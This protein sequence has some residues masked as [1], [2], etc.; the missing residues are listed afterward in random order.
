VKILFIGVNWITK[1]IITEMLFEDSDEELELRVIGQDTAEWFWTEVPRLK[2]YMGDERV[3]YYPNNVLHASHLAGCDAIYITDCEPDILD[4][5]LDDLNQNKYD[6]PIILASSWQVYGWKKKKRTPI[7]ETDRD[8]NPENKEAKNLLELEKVM[9]K[10]KTLQT[11]ILRYAE[12]IGPYMPDGSEVLNLMIDALSSEEIDVYPPPSRNYDWL[13]VKFIYNLVPKLFKRKFIGGGEIYN[14]G[15]GEERK[16]TWLANSLRQLTNSQAPVK[17]HE[18]ENFDVQPRGYHSLLDCEKAKR[19]LQYEPDG[20][21]IQSFLEIT[22]WVESD[23]PQAERIILDH[24]Q[25]P[26]LQDTYPM[27][28]PEWGTDNITFKDDR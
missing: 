17:I 23:L 5:N 20:I 19:F 13:H 16:I 28:K 4:R 7:L 10:Y 11:V 3:E 9:L 27:L 25:A 6:G 18:P 1:W 26:S 2:E 24:P 14:I 21:R 8:L 12:V 22:R 15:S